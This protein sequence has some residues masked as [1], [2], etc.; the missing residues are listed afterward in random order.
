MTIAQSIDELRARHL[1]AIMQL[2]AA[3]PQEITPKNSSLLEECAYQLNTGGKRLRALLPLVIA[4]ALGNDPAKLVP[5]GAACEMLHN[6]T[7]VHDD[8]QDGD[9]ERRGAPTVWKRYGL[10]AAINCG[11]AMFY[12]ALSLLY[13]LDITAEQKVALSSFFMQ[14][15]LKVING[16][17]LEFALQKAENPTLAQYSV[18][19]EGK[20]SGLFALPIVGAAKIC[21]AAPAIQEAL[22]NAAKYLGILFQIQDDFLDIY[23]QKGRAFVGSDIAEGKRSFLAL[24]ALSATKDHG[25]LR[26]ILDT[27][28]NETSKEMIA[29]AI[30]IFDSVD[31]AGAALQEINTLKNKAMDAVSAT[32]FPGAAELI[33]AI[34]DMLLV[35]IK[36]EPRLITG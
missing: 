19:V 3:G 7:L 23:G 35:A 21:G 6:A 17:E 15:T 11:D 20:T 29:E 16:Q 27:P 12:Y 25:R 8:V 36:D 31:T 9:D 22:A 1:P 10:P 34:A 32:L 2:L 28:R 24:Y 13:T 18:M 5:F 14:E 26:A 4:Q 33:S 30:A